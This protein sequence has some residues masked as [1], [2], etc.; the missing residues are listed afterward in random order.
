EIVVYVGRDKKTALIIDIQAFQNNE[1]IYQKGYIRIYHFSP[2]NK[3]E[4]NSLDPNRVVVYDQQHLKVFGDDQM[5]RLITGQLQLIVTSAYIY[6]YPELVRQLSVKNLIF[7]GVEPIANGRVDFT[8]SSSFSKNVKI[9]LRSDKDSS[10]QERIFTVFTNQ[11]HAFSISRPFQAFLGLKI[12]KDIR[13][14]YVTNFDE[15]ILGDTFKEEIPSIYERFPD[16]KRGKKIFSTYTEQGLIYQLSKLKI[17]EYIVTNKRIAESGVVSWLKEDIRIPFKKMKLA[18]ALMEELH[19]KNKKIIYIKIKLALDQS[20]INVAI[21]RDEHNQIR[22]FKIDTG[23]KVYVIKVL[24]AVGQIAG[25]ENI[26][27]TFTHKRHSLIIHW[28]AKSKFTGILS[29]GF[30]LLKTKGKAMRIFDMFSNPP[31]AYRADQLSE[32]AAIRFSEGQIESFQLHDGQILQAAD[33]RVKLKGKILLDEQEKVLKRYR[34]V[35]LQIIEK[36]YRLHQWLY[37]LLEFTEEDVVSFTYS[38]VIKQLETTVIDE[39]LN[40]DALRIMAQRAFAVNI[41]QEIQRQWGLNSAQQN[42]LLRAILFL[43]K[44]KQW[45]SR[46]DLKN[47]VGIKENVMDTILN[48]LAK[49]QLQRASLGSGG[50]EK[51]SSDKIIVHPESLKGHN[52]IIEN[53]LAKIQD[54]RLIKAMGKLTPLEAEIVT[55]RLGYGTSFEVIA[56]SVGKMEEEVVSIFDQA[57]KK[58]GNGNGNRH[59]ND[60][61]GSSP[62]DSKDQQKIE[63]IRAKNK[64]DQLQEIRNLEKIKTREDIYSLTNEEWD[65]IRDISLQNRHKIFYIPKDR[66]TIRLDNSQKILGFN[67]KTE[68]NIRKISFETPLL[69]ASHVN[70]YG[71]IDIDYSDSVYLSR[72]FKGRIGYTII[73]NGIMVGLYFPEIAKLSEVVVHI[74]RD[75]ETALI[76]DVKAFELNA[77]V[78]QKS[79][80]RIYRFKMEKKTVSLTDF[81]ASR[82]VVSDKHYLKVFDKDQISQLVPGHLQLIM[83]SAY[84]YKYAGFVKEM[85]SDDLLF[86]GIIANEKGSIYLTQM[87]DDDNT[88]K[89]KVSILPYFKRQGDNDERFFTVLQGHYRAFSL[90]PSKLNEPFEAFLGLKVENSGGIN[91]FEESILGE[92][93]KSKGMS[94]YEILE[95]GEKGK[96]LF[97]SRNRSSL[98]RKLVSLNL[99]KYIVTN[100]RMNGT[101]L[102]VWNKRKINIPVSKMKLANA[103]IEEMSVRNNKISYVRIKLNYEESII[104]V[105]IVRDEYNRIKYFRI[106]DGKTVKLMKGLTAVGKILGDENFVKTIT[107]KRKNSIFRWARANKFTGVIYGAFNIFKIKNEEARIFDTSS[108]IKY[109][110]ISERLNELASI[111]FLEGNITEFHFS[112]GSLI[113][114]EEIE[115]PLKGE[116]SLEEQ[117][118][119]LNRHKDLIFKIAMKEYYQRKWFYHVLGLIEEDII[120]LTEFYVLKEYE[121][122]VIGEKVSADVLRLRARRYFIQHLNSQIKLRWGLKD[123]HQSLLWQLIKYYHQIKR[124]VTREELINKFGIKDEEKIEIILD[125]LMKYYLKEVSLDSKSR[126]EEDSLYRTI[127]HSDSSKD[128]E[129]IIEEQLAEIQD[130]RLIKAM[131]KL[132]P[133]E[134]KIITDHLGYGESFA[135]IA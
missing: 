52:K 56:Q 127:P 103:V 76:T 79:Y 9:S 46:E 133:L 8:L 124:K 55:D 23:K 41:N 13:S 61:N 59:E 114:K 115:K 62:M 29:G 57:W 126:E 60:L 83:T 54:P 134:V 4:L 38:Y 106:D 25:R 135:E 132:T 24:T 128:Y 104:N 96:K 80:V 67:Q 36:E 64:F 112:D 22:Y 100:Q 86:V 35:I 7:V 97:S 90:L 6:Q 10:R 117:K 66:I 18:N 2:E 48:I 72:E 11:Y 69:I 28:A 12:R 116:L 43:K 131:Q 30:N 15:S 78:Y 16:G 113:R 20:I 89:I 40:E 91:N 108:N 95:N 118:I 119:A 39:E 71:A 121:V 63:I 70:A 32:L 94:V 26:T 85:S 92:Y 82:I 109:A 14:S 87:V 123:S 47:I 84:I 81:N 75:R 130:P 125:S 27:K 93:P 34:H 58:I 53:Q 42:Q 74:I 122:S 99:D 1:I 51:D 50:A 45:V 77:I 107:H 19:V 37:Q 17:S 31:V 49:Y 98:L 88:K 65:R 101:G 3:E 111:T 120:R 129:N 21:E 110:Y 105:Q 44:N 33:I 68:I 5:A 102:L 73:K